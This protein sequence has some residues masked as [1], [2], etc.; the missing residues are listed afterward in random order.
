MIQRSKLKYSTKQSQIVKIE[1]Q[2]I[3]KA[4]KENKILL[5]SIFK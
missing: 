3:L 1:S 4:Y 2:K 5:K